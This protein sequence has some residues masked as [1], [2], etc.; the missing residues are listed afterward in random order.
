MSNELQN[1]Q[2]QNATCYRLSNTWV[3]LVRS[4]STWMVLIS[5]MVTGITFVNGNNVSRNEAI[6]EGL[7]WFRQQP[8]PLRTDL[9]FLRR[10]QSLHLYVHTP[11]DQLLNMVSDN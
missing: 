8:F 2:K 6:T 4:N 10:K 9:V 3:R 11:D 1:K 5:G 7:S